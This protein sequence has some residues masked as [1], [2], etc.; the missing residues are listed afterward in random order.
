MAATPCLRLLALIL[1]ASDSL[2]SSADAGVKISQVFTKL[3]LYVAGNQAV[4]LR[5]YMS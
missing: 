2:I 3:L 5:V 1:L 4:Y